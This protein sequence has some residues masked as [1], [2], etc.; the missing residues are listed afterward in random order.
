LKSIYE[1]LRPDQK[2]IIWTCYRRDC[3][4]IYDAFVLIGEK[5]VKY[6]GEMKAEDKNKSVDEFQNNP[7]CRIFIATVQAAGRSISLTAASYAVYYSNDYSLEHRLQSEDRP[8][9]TGLKNDLTIIDIIARK[10]VDESI[11]EALIGK[12]NLAE[13]L[14]NTKKLFFGEEI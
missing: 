5:P 3:Q 11:C 14:V 7:N 6:T 2:I 9:R 1:G 10:T 8:H 12:K 13:T 4:K